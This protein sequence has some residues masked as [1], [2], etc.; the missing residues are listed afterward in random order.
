[1]TEDEGPFVAFNV[2]TDKLPSKGEGPFKCENCKDNF[3]VCEEHDNVPFTGRDQECCGGAGMPCP[4]CN[5]VEPPEFPRMP[6]GT[7][8]VWH[9]DKG[10]VQ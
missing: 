8:E 10:T 5:A 1:M 6:P 3:W 7:V 2:D 4:Q 9:R